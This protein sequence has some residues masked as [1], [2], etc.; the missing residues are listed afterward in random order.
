MIRLWYQPLLCLSLVF[1]FIHS[2]LE[3][4]QA[5]ALIVA[6]AQVQ[7]ETDYIMSTIMSPYCPGRL[8]KDC[9]S[10]QAYELKSRI[11]SRLRAGE[12]TQ[13]IVEDLIVKF[14]EEIRAAPKATGFGIVAWLSPFVFLLVGL[15]LLMMWLRR[16]SEA[17]VEYVR[18]QDTTELEKR[19]N[20]QLNR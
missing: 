4:Q 16:Q 20:E 2:V 18:E 15:I 14:G 19:I 6:D 7:S 1:C 3:A 9:P 8:L 13:D 17:E 12:A 11:E 10:G 5:P